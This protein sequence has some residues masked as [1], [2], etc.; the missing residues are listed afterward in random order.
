MFNFPIFFLGLYFALSNYML[1][2]D[3]KHFKNFYNVSAFKFDKKAK[4]TVENT[5]IDSTLLLFPKGI[6]K[7]VK[8]NAQFK[9]VEYQ[10]KYQIKYLIVSDINTISL[11]PSIKQ[12]NSFESIVGKTKEDGYVLMNAGMF[13]PNFNA[14]GLTISAGEIKQDLDTSITTPKNGNFYLYPNGIFTIDKK[15]NPSIHTTKD[16]LEKKIDPKGLL[17]AT[18]SG[19]M[20]V[21]DNKIHDKFSATSKNTNVRNGVGINDKGQ[22][23][24]AIS[25]TE[26]TF[27][28]FATFFKDEL[29]CSYALYL[30]GTISE[31]YYRDKKNIWHTPRISSGKFGPIF[32]VRL[33]EEKK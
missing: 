16:F 7:G 5:E 33:Q 31:I 28:D 17:L 18:Q 20:L 25:E 29:H 6:P 14:V 3:F 27:H 19:P 12:A 10:A 22:I 13:Q 30:D 21:I 11:I 8:E 4:K 15:N 26:I 24:F 1:D 2:N 23:V 9:S 32:M